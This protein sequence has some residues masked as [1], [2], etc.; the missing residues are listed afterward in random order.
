VFFFLQNIYKES[1]LIKILH[2]SI[3]YV[4]NTINDIKK[5]ESEKLNIILYSR[6][7]ILPVY[8]DQHFQSVNEKYCFKSEYYRDCQEDLEV[9]QC[10]YYNTI[11]ACIFVIITNKNTLDHFSY[12]N[13]EKGLTK[14]KM[15]I[16][17]DQWHPTFII[18]T[19]RNRLFESLINQKIVSLI[20]SK[21][22]SMTP[23][24]VFVIKN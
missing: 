19:L 11:E 21:F 9:G 16:E 18:H 12:Q 13:L 7:T 17:K 14:I 15:L 4:K 6:T 1:Q 23:C 22:L 2:P 5:R 20:S 3:V 8:W 10:L 24:V